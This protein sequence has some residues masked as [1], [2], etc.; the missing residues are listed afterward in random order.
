MK[1]AIL[2]ASGNLGSQLEKIF[3]GYELLPWDK[4]DF[5]FLDFDVLR[6]N[7]NQSNPDLIINA[8]AYNAV[9]Q[10]EA[11]NQERD[12]AFRLNRDLPALLAG[13]CSENE[14][15][16]IHYSTDYVFGGDARKE[17]CE[18]DEVAPLNVYGLSKAEGERAILEMAGNWRH[19]VIRTSK[20]FGPAG[21]SQFSKP[22]FFQ[23]IS[24]VASEKGKVDIVDSELSCF[25][26][27]PDLAQATKELYEREYPSGIYHIT[28]S[29]PATW[30]QA[31][32]YLFSLSGQDIDIN[33]VSSDKFPRLAK[34]PESSILINTKFLPQRDFREALGEYLKTINI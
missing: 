22:S 8:A 16:L 18:D 9:D 10:C 32:L 13:W 34:R 31:A 17:F 11:N 24:R 14:S 19:Y 30:Y 29:G 15:A 6:H 4:D 27:T 3:L 25:T 12:L 20:L 21:S 26:Y 23:A 33:P 5:D 2:G 1:V 7:L 28:N